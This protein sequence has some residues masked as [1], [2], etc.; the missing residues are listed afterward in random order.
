MYNFELNDENIENWVVKNDFEIEYKLD[1]P[2][3]NTIKVN[4]YNCYCIIK[5]HDF[6]LGDT[7]NKTFTITEAIFRLHASV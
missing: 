6:K 4:A 7:F 2:H 3:N 5:I 1:I